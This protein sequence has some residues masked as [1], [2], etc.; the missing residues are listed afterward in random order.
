M[1]QGQG[2]K[3]QNNNAI[4]VRSRSVT[5]VVE[6]IE[7]VEETVTID[8]KTQAKLTETPAAT[9][10]SS[11]LGSTVL[12]RPA[13]VAKPAKP[14]V[15]DLPRSQE[16]VAEVQGS[17]D[18]PGEYRLVSLSSAGRLGMPESLH[19]R[20]YNGADSQ[21][22]ATM[23]ADNQLELLLGVLKGLIWEKIDV[24]QLHEEDVKELLL[25]IHLLFWGPDIKDY[26]YPFTDEEYSLLPVEKQKAI[27]S[28]EEYPTVDIHIP[29]IGTTPIKE[30]AREPIVIKQ[31]DTTIEF[32]VPRIGDEVY[33]ERMVS[34][35]FARRA[36]EMRRISMK[37]RQEA[38]ARL[39]KQEVPFID[40]VEK[41]EYQEYR[42]ERELLKMSI[43]QAQ[44]IL[45]YNGKPLETIEEK[46]RVQ[47]RI[48][49]QWWSRVRKITEEHFTFGVDGFVEMRNP[50][51]QEVVSRKV[52]FQPMELVPSDRLEGVDEFTVELGG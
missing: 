11:P 31:G 34:K 43:K 26:F 6:E 45:S 51:T 13:V 42:Q 29:R 33:A 30:T 24:M 27:E 52:S 7:Q 47:E 28:G 9:T 22:L 10:V 36:E 38:R 44:Q 37:L 4:P 48:S 25:N 15:L 12:P 2:L 23:V 16:V 17:L 32:R 19:V 35:H 46:I 3:L 21:K 39:F 5:T 40:P 50:W 8:P 49:T 1:E 41:E 18:I 20:D 14:V